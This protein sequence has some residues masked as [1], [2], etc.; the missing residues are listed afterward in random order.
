[1]VNATVTPAPAAL[2]Q[3]NPQTLS[4][5]HLFPPPTATL[6]PVTTPAATTPSSSGAASQPSAV[7]P[8]TDASLKTKV[9]APPSP[10]AYEPAN[11]AAVGTGKL[12][13]S[14]PTSAD[15]YVGDK[16]L[17]STPITLDLPAGTHTLEY[18]HDNLRTVGTHVV[19]PNETTTALIT[20]EIVV[21]INSR[22]WAQVYLDGA[23]RR[24]LGQTPLSD[25][26]V[27][28]GRILVFENPNFPS[29]SY[30]ITG[31]ETAI[32]MVFP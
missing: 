23:Q 3:T 7:P 28:I 26:K 29:K 19:K 24:A 31:K 27:P 30:R 18:R 2:P 17:G 9:S 32:Q 11:L 16:H 15:I 8:V 20:F 14:S 4:T 13:I 25:V 5:D 22:P 21:Q 10:V 12:A 1:M 6:P